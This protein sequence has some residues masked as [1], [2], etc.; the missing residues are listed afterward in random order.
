MRTSLK[1]RATR[2][3]GALGAAVLV[4]M[5]ATGVAASAGAIVAN[6]DGLA[7]AMGQ[8][9]EDEANTALAPAGATLTARWIDEGAGYLRTTGTDL[10]ALTTPSAD[11]VRIDFD[12]NMDLVEV[13][14]GAPI[15]TSLSAG[16]DAAGALIAFDSFTAS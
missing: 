6:F 9:G 3:V 15:S 14:I 2:W 8:A 5:A 10:I 12:Q 1:G 16:Y 13:R 4:I 7:V 11:D